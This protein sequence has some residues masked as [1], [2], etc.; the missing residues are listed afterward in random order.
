MQVTKDYLQG[1]ID[2]LKKQHEQHIANANAVSGALQV[3]EQLMGYLETP[4]EKT[5][6]TT[7]E[8]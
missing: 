4:E 8:S 3:Y 2:H 5:E 6:E 7:V 1:Q